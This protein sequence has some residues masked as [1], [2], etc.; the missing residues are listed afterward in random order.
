[1]SSGKTVVVVYYSMYGHVQALAK[2]VCKG[3]QRS[4]GFHYTKEKITFEI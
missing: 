3:L 2:E 4:G 1:M